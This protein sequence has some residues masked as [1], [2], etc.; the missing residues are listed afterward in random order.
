MKR[1][2]KYKLP[3]DGEVVTINASVIKW[4][5]VQEQDG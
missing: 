3:R 5:D 4:L 1:I 2:F